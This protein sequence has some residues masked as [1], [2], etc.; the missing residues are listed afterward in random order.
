MVLGFALVLLGF[1]AL[2]MGI[3]SLTFGIVMGFDAKFELE[4][5]I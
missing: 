5:G 3:W 1:V 4:A 2:G